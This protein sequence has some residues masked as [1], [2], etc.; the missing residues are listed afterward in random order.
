MD[1]PYQ[2]NNMQKVISVLAIIIF[3]MTISLAQLATSAWPTCR[4][5]LQ[6]TGLSQ[7]NG[8]SMPTQKWTFLTGDVIKSIPAIATDGTIYFGSDDKNVY[9][10]NP[11]GT[12]KWKFTTGGAVQS[13]PVIGKDGTIYIGSND[14]KF[15]ALSPNGTKKW[16]FITKGHIEESA[17]IGTD[18]TIYIGSYE[19]TNF[20]ALNPDGTKKWEFFIND[21]AIA[22]PAI[23]QDGS[24]IYVAT[25]GN[26]FA[27]N[28]DGTKKWS[29]RRRI[30]K[31][32]P[33]IGADGT[34]YS[35]SNY[36]HLYALNN[37][38]GKDKWTYNPA[39]AVDT[40]SPA[41]AADG[42]IYI[43]SIDSCLYAANP[44]GSQKWK[45]NLGAIIQ[46]S[47]VIGADGTIYIGSN[48]NKIDAL[49]SDGTL[50]WSFFVGGFVNSSPAIADD[51][52]I[53]VGSNNHKLYAIGNITIKPTI[54]VTAPIGAEQWQQGSTQQITWT[55]TGSPECVKVE[56]YKGGV[57]DCTISDAAQNTGTINWTI[58]AMQKVGTDYKV[59]ISA[60]SDTSVTSQ[61]SAN[62]SITTGT[63][64]NIPW[65]MYMHDVQHTGRSPYKGPTNPA[66]KWGVGSIKPIYAS[67]AI[68]TDGTIYTKVCDDFSTTI[69]AI[70]SDGTQKWSFFID[71][72][73]YHALS[74]VIGA[75][76]TVYYGQSFKVYA[77]NP[78][79]GTQKWTFTTSDVVDSSLVIDKDGTLYFG[80]F[81][82]KLY[83]IN[84]D[85]T[86]K[87]VFT[88]GGSISSCPAIATDG[89]IYFGAD[90][91]KLYALNNDG[92]KKWEFSTGDKIA[93]S[94]NISIDG[95][96]YFGSDDFNFYALNPDG[97]K[98]WSFATKEKVSA[99]AAIGGDGTIYFG[100][101]DNYFYALN[102]DGT[103]KWAHLSGGFIDTASPVID[104]G[105]TIYVGI[106]GVS[107]DFEVIAFNPDGTIK[108]AF[109]SP[110]VGAM[111]GNNAN[112]TIGSDG[113]IYMETGF[114]NGALYCITTAGPSVTVTSPNGGEQ[115]LR[116]VSHPITWTSTGN[117]G[118]VKIELYKGG[119]LNS[120]IAS[121]VV[122]NGTYNW[123]ILTSQLAGTDYQVKISSVTTATITDSS[124]ANF[125]VIT[126]APKPTIN[127]TA[128]N[129]GEQWQQGTIN[130]ITWTYTGNPGN[131]K[132]ELLKTGKVVST[133]ANSVTN[134]GTYS[135][136]IPLTQ[137]AGTDYRVKV[138]SVTD[139]TVTG[140]SAADFA[141]T[142][143]PKPT[144]TITTPNGGE[145]WQVGTANNII[146]TSTSVTG[147]VKIDLYKGTVLDSTIAA[148]V[149]NT[150]TYNWTIPAIQTAGT[151]YK[152]KISSVT[153]TTV[154]GQSA[155]DFTVTTKQNGSGLAKSA[156][157]MYHHDLQHTGRSPY[158][159]PATAAQKW[160]F[161][162]GGKVNS[163]PA[164]SVDGTV[165]VGSD[166]GKL[167]A[168]NP[169]GTQRWTFTTGQMISS[170]PAICADGTVY[171]G[172]LDS[173]LYAINP[174]GTQR[175]TFTTGNSIN[176]SP[177]LGA[178]GTVY[179]GS[180]DKKLY[181]INP[182]GTQRWTFT[183]GGDI[184]SSP[185]LSVD[186][187]VY[188]GAG[189]RKLYAVN[190]DGTQ[191]WT[192]TAGDLI[193]SSPAIG[194]DGTV[195]VGSNDN[196]LYAINPDGTQ[197]WAFTTGSS[198]LSSPAL[199]TDG[200]VYV[201]SEDGNLYAIYPDG[202]QRWT[203]T[204]GCQ[205]LS[206]PALGADG[207]V[208]VGSSSD[209]TL[210]AINPNGK[211]RWAFKTSHYIL[212][213]SPALGAD[214]TVYI[215]SIDGNLYAIGKQTPTITVTAPNGGEQWQQGTINP[216]T[217]TYTGN[218]GNVKIEVLKTGK[219]IS[220][221]A[222][223]V[224]NSGTYSW[225]IPLTQTAGTDYRVKV[226][227]VT[228]TT[229]T[230][231]SAADFA[232]TAAPKPTIT[233]TTPN[234]SEIWQR[235]IAHT[236]TWT[237]TS[238]TGN[239]KIE[240]YKGGTLDSAI[241]A[242]VANNGTYSWTI[243]ATQTAGTNYKVK[244]ISVTTTTVTSQSAND[245][246]ISVAAPLSAW[247]MFRHNSQHTGV[248]PFNGPVAPQKLW[249]YSAGA[250]IQ[251]SP[252]ISA[253]G[254]TYFGSDDNKLY[255]VKADGTLKWTFTT[256]NTIINTPA[257]ATD[258]TVYIN[259]ND[260]Y[261]YAVNPDGT[262]K[263]KYLLNTIARSSPMLGP[264]GTIYIGGY[265]FR[266]YA[267]NADGTLKWKFNTGGIVDATAA[268]SPDGTAYIGSTDTKLYA[269]N[270]DGTQKWVYTSGGAIYSSA[271][272]AKDGTIY[273]G[274]ND[275]KLY[276]LNTDGS[277]KWTFVTG[278]AINSP[279]IGADGTIYIGSN[280]KKIYAV[281]PDGTQKWS[282]LTG[283]TFGYSSIAIGAD[284]II[285]AGCGDNKAYA[286][287]TDGTLLWTYL[288]GG[289]VN[290]PSIGADGK[291]YLCSADKKLYAI[292]NV[293]TTVTV[294]APNGTEQWQQGSTQNITWT[295]TG[296]PGNVKI[297][298]YKN[299]V[300]NSVIA[301]N[302][303][304]KS[305]YS[306]TIPTG[307]TIGTDYKVK[308]SAVTNAKITDISDANFA[309]TAA[310]VLGIPV[311]LSPS[312]NAV[313][314]TAPVTIAWQAV[315]T[316]VSYEYELYGPAKIGRAHV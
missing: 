144:I 1:T 95:S 203:F 196:K 285:Y 33:A 238:V 277:L 257:I 295:S 118:N 256:G 28:S 2:E 293:P 195:Y 153:T 125:A 272:V 235:G 189:D 31:S 62:F 146:W 43:G 117:I 79:D 151:N 204:S 111:D 34:I 32:G 276:A 57:L 139:T 20:Y 3:A 298:L 138:S 302:I 145:Q 222:T 207:T 197:R 248:S 65:P 10:L 212:H 37:A 242:S 168:I 83:A 42:T 137:T 181:A 27:I 294:T 269:L 185:A 225:N 206:S 81:D 259:S 164:L 75:D 49:N 303:P 102:S 98:K 36:E 315:N 270:A 266:L 245:F 113:N 71:N 296:T 130:P 4:H 271:A 162:T 223:S 313:N 108:W 154:V 68:S 127:I 290:S 135:W 161:M 200:T 5:N 88:A 44:D 77:F 142:A 304:S 50:K 40:C 208:Y 53:Y 55:S 274:S 82:K 93:S 171:V 60:M 202:K 9:A 236:I 8:P 163:S 30:Q 73:F 219:V 119:M 201:G 218:P 64:G 149:A 194:A 66:L 13:S 247:P 156:W 234:G 273:V 97:T 47:P 150:G 109:H 15:Y 104:A 193:Y 286:L 29:T 281:N 52:T 216:I 191:R 262:E 214:G 186:G 107:W 54:T 258:G 215:G 306:W 86:Q 241:A 16:E 170:S 72:S 7:Y 280:D 46:S 25:I 190:P 254:T 132:I 301:A 229:V 230:G 6:N 78:V 115:W 312:N 182:D 233:I 148:S 177:V 70:K 166:D 264:D 311:Q 213:S 231:Q 279:A 309:I 58:P 228:D 237:S 61:S 38:D 165:Y 159:G 167:Y 89:T 35:G 41:I 260:K 56:L 187:T 67:P 178:D 227:S 297:D 90:D 244:I 100:S 240:L 284:G 160:A 174:N 128:P 226:S 180:E 282:Y 114:G 87:W 76:G 69:R 84:P 59:K 140:Q 199:G 175:W 74:P 205:I 275:N 291:L 292:G 91:S 129:G 268:M 169:D 121:N 110:T 217:W 147:N 133:L 105:G 152:V 265:D 183:T 85:G 243:P 96:I 48:N 253:D 289:S 250:N 124:N 263:W 106:N 136:N 23:S 19:D 157:P 210:Y 246:A 80:T 314:V 39:A 176:S 94:P 278:N 184:Y 120:V 173:K 18:G 123:N 220:T 21:C 155:A 288:T 122:N 99:T 126:T 299:G 143:A 300:L 305:P 232:I 22:S 310:P 103:Q 51:G 112:P 26:I 92:T 45:Y 209:S 188:I 12:Q 24:V 251:S 316:A 198:V 11:D 63:P 116:G 255:A 221:L 239:V 192:F 14:T 172:S 283:G 308:I 249:E 134:S 287:N 261:I 179:I 224:A 252:V 141:I 158:T 307:Q 131:V 101:Q 267:L 211:Q 17:T